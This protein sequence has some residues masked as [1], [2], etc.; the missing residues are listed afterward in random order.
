[1]AKLVG[2]SETPIYIENWVV[3]IRSKE[4]GSRCMYT[5]E[6]KVSLSLKSE[7]VWVLWIPYLVIDNIVQ[8][9][10]FND[11]EREPK[12]KSMVVLDLLMSYWWWVMFSDDENHQP[13]GYPLGERRWL[14]LRGEMVVKV[15]WEASIGGRATRVGLNV[16]GS[17]FLFMVLK[18]VNWWN[19]IQIVKV[20]LLELD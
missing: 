5:K 10:W 3:H 7:A 18:L 14:R 20:S 6:T 19:T 15:N 9:G 13:S 12:I 4:E 17:W 8:V 2:F 16:A 11:E 1:M